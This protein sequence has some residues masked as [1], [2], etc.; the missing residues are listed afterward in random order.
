MKP[1]LIICLSSFVLLI[2]INLDE[3]ESDRKDAATALLMYLFIPTFLT[4]IIGS[5]TMLI[6]ELI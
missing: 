2:L 6:S 4:V 1:I 3:N 5:I